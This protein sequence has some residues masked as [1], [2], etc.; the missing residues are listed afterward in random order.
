MLEAVFDHVTEIVTGFGQLGV[1]AQRIGSQAAARMKGYLDS[2]AFAGPYL[3]DQ[4]LLP[5][6]LAGNGVFTTV[7]PSKHTETSASII[8]R[9]LDLEIRFER[10]SGGASLVTVGR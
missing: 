10:H 4:L 9:F 6:A 8:R 7:T 1:S 2:S 5:M 3:A